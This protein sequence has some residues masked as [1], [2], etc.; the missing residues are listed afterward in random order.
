MIGR[1]GVSPF[2]IRNNKIKFK[3]NEGFFKF[4]F[5]FFWWLG[6]GGIAP[7]WTF[8]KEDQIWFSRANKF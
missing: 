4:F 6:G 3:I 2:M 8:F 1:W 7:I 5:F